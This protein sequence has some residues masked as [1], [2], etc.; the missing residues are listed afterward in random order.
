MLEADLRAPKSSPRILIGNKSDVA[1][2][3]IKRQVPYEAGLALA[4]FYQIPFFETNT[5]D[6]SEFRAAMVHMVEEIMNIPNYIPGEDVCS[7]RFHGLSEKSPK[8]CSIC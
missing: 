1:I 4:Q 6:D 5:T 2:E 7:S 8:K 3:G